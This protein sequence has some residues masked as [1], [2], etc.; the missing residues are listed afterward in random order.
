M[1]NPIAKKDRLAM[2][3]KLRSIIK[4]TQKSGYLLPEDSSTLS[5]IGFSVVT[6]LIDAGRGKVG[7]KEA[8]RSVAGG[9]VSY[10]EL[11]GIIYANTH[12]YSVAPWGGPLGYTEI[13]GSQKPDKPLPAEWLLTPVGIVIIFGF[14]LRA[15]GSFTWLQVGVFSVA[16]GLIITALVFVVL[17]YIAARTLKGVDLGGPYEY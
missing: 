5:T 14:V 12:G 4:R 9:E 11:Q 10:N 8:T 2:L 6:G 15:L 13:Y 7:V 17:I 16:G 3:V 1:N